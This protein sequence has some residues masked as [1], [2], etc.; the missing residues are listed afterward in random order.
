VSEELFLEISPIFI[1]GIIS[2]SG[3]PK[4]N[5]S[6]KYEN[7]HEKQLD[8]SSGENFWFMNPEIWVLHIS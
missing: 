4:Y 5:F 8:K 2:V 6:A 3:K 1:C 7:Y